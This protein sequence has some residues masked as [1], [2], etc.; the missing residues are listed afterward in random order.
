[1]NK[2]SRR[3]FLQASA[4]GLAAAG[5]GP[6]LTACSQAGT[7]EEQKNPIL[8]QLGMASYTF[9]AFPLEEALAMTVR[10]AIKNIAFKSFHLPLDSTA[11]QIAEVVKKVKD[12]GLNLYGGGVIYMKNEDE[13][14]QAFD[15]AR[16]AGMKVIIGAPNHELLP[17]VEQKVKDYGIKLAIHNHGPGDELYPT[18]ASIIEKIGN[19]DPRMGLCL[20]IGHTVRVGGDPAKDAEDY[21]SRLF[22]VHIKDESSATPEGETIEIGRGVIDIPA[23]LAALTR[24]GYKGMVSFEFEK[25]EHDPL[26]G[27]AESVGYVRGVLGTF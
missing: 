16:N 8:F 6:V 12:A 20:D 19:M 14:N 17:L 2:H 26:P 27:L 21:A 13:V 24:T 25:D 23:F 3:T 4:L 1:M 7:K 22:D 18:A 11:E 5:T 15:Y 10:L 9:R